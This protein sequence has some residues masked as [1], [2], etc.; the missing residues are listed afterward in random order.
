MRWRRRRRRR[1]RRLVVPDTIWSKS[2]CTRTTHLWFHID[3]HSMKFFIICKELFIFFNEMDR[4]FLQG[5]VLLR[6]VLDIDYKLLMVK[7]LQ[8][9]YKFS[10]IVLQ[11]PYTRFLSGPQDDPTSIHKSRLKSKW[12]EGSSYYLFLNRLLYVSWK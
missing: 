7:T 5:R 12:V 8:V 6:L 10:V 11:S 9:V 3:N 1:R 2:G 4:M